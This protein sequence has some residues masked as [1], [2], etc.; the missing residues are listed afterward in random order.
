MAC[1]SRACQKL[2]QMVGDFSTLEQ[3]IGESEGF[4]KFGEFYNGYARVSV[5]MPNTFTLP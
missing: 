1:S 3:N 4:E 2:L 5:A